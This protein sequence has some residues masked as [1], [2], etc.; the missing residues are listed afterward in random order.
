VRAPRGGDRPLDVRGVALVHRREDV[1][2]VVG[3]HCLERLAAA[4]LLAADD[5]RNLD[6]VRAHLLEAN[7][8]LLTFGRSRRVVLDRLVLG[9]RRTE[10]TRGGG[11]RTRL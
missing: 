10:K 6:L 11:H 1:L 9:S 7:A 8:K 3:H 5:E 4:D 2:A